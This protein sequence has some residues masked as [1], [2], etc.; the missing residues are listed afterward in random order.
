ME[1]KGLFFLLRN[2]IDKISDTLGLVSVSII[3]GF[4]FLFIFN[5]HQTSQNHQ[6]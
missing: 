2:N 6:L 4:S 5:F 3:I 1:L